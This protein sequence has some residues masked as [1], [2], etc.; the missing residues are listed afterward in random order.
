[1]LGFEVNDQ[2]P[3]MRRQQ[4]PILCT[5]GCGLDEEARH[6]FLVKAHGLPPHCPLGSSCL[7]SPLSC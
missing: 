5:G 2:L 7:L 3:Q 6:A 1:M 4:A